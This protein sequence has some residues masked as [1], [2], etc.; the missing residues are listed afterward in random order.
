A[1]SAA[2]QMAQDIAKN[3]A[4]GGSQRRWTISV[5]VEGF[6]D[7]AAADQ[8]KRRGAETVGYRPNASVAVLG[9][10]EPGDTQRRFLTREEQNRLSGS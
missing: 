7:P 10:G 2:S 3:N 5:Q 6:G 4:S 1:A 8:K 9:L